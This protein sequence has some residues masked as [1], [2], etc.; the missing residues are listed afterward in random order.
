MSLADIKLN[1]INRSH[2]INNPS[3]VIFQKNVATRFDD[4]AVA[5]RV[6]NNCGQGDHYAFTYAG[7][8]AVATS[9]S[10]GNFTPQLAAKEGQ[11]FQVTETGAG[12]ALSYVGPSA[13][14]REIQVENA[15]ERGAISAHIFRGGKLAALKHAIAPQQKAVFEF[16][17][18]LW[19]GVAAQIEEGQVM[20]SA[21]ISTINTELSL[22]GIASADIVMSGGGPGPSSTPFTFSLENLRAA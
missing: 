20:N 10:R 4:L 1:F 3:V 21:I 18:T 14:P 12:Q 2:D 5:W 6:I 22:L 8:F 17:P 19:I 16:K 15:L 11:L 13:A 9:D 7:G